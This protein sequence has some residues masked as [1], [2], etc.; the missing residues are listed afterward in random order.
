MK[1][2]IEYDYKSWF[3]NAYEASTKID[4]RRYARL[5]K[6][7]EEAKED[8][9][10]EISRDRIVPEIPLPEEVELDTTCPECSGTG[11]MDEVIK[12][13]FASDRIS[14]RYKKVPCNKC[15]ED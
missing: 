4:G 15:Q 10:E 12:E 5:A 6:S 7:F 1:I 8:L 3:D 11:E 13:S 9:L 14:P 2:L